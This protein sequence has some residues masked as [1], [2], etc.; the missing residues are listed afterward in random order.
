MVR[1]FNSTKLSR[2]APSVTPTYQSILE[3]SL[4][5]RRSDNQ[6]ASRTP[7]ILSK[8]ILRFIKK[9]T[10]NDLNCSFPHVFEASNLTSSSF[11][12][13]GNTP[14]F[15][16]GFVRRRVSIVSSGG[17]E[18]KRRTHRMSLALIYQNHQ[19]YRYILLQ[20]ILLFRFRRH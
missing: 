12:A 5:A 6:S 1:S 4:R 14:R 11:G 17:G 9:S 13:V 16:R 10:P 15:S 7:K 18:S 19:I 3:K 2:R 8:S 20:T